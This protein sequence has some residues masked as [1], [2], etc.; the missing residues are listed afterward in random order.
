MTST[1]AGADVVIA[2]FQTHFACA[3]A[4]RHCPM[5]FTSVS[6]EGLCDEQLG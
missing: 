3:K 4:E 2:P 5:G 1:K 6:K